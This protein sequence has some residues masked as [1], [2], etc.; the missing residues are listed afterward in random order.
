M[1]FA[2]EDFERKN[3]GTLYVKVHIFNWQIIP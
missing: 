2:A 1:D 3:D